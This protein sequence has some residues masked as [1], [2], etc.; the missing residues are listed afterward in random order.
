MFVFLALL[1]GAKLAGFWGVFLAVPVAGIINI[2]AR[3]AYEVARGRLVER[4]PR[5]RELPGVLDDQVGERLGVGP[6]KI[7]E[8]EGVLHVSRVGLG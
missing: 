3:Y 5:S 6:V 8:G 7:L 1:L 2:F 4:V